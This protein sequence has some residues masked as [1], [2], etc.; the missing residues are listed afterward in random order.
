M[1]T[2][3]V[4]SIAVFL[5]CANH[6]DAQ[7]LP[8]MKEPSRTAD[9]H[10]VDATACLRGSNSS[11]PYGLMKAA[12]LH[13]HGKVPID[14]SSR[15]LSHL[16]ENLIRGFAGT[17]SPGYKGDGII[18]LNAA[19]HHPQGVA[20]D[21]LGNVYIADSA[22][23]RIRKVMVD[24]GIIITVAGSGITGYNGDGIIA[25][26]AKLFFPTSVAIDGSYNI[27]IADNMNHRIRKVTVLDN[28]ITT[29]AGTGS[30]G[31]NGDGIKATSAKLNAPNGIAL[32]TSNNIYIADTYNNRIRKLTVSTGII[33][34]VAG[35]GD[36]PGFFKGEGIAA[37]SIYLRMPFNVHIDGFGDIY[38]ADTYNHRV[39]KVTVSTGK[40]TT[41][42]GT[43]S[44]GYNGDGIKATSARLTDPTGISS[45][46]LGDIYI[47][48]TLDN[49]IRKVSM[50]T[51]IITTVAGTGPFGTGTGDYN[52]DF[53]EATSARLNC[54]YDVAVDWFGHVFIADTNNNRIRFITRDVFNGPP[55]IA[56]PAVT[57]PP[58]TSPPVASPAVTSPP[59]VSRS[60]SRKRTRRPSSAPRKKTPNDSCAPRN[61]LR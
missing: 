50:S 11:S 35:A 44:P 3:F 46:Y 25:T 61:S 38:I 2:S 15:T 13:S 9:D 31:Y 7:K 32:D 49:R 27:Y 18:A 53:I 47:A 8:L 56:S 28:I 45:D 21:F 37:T 24:T 16:R 20:V 54:P 26:S 33:T 10:V 51:G 60:P 19:V 36:G 41:V 1:L 29:V 6:V 48:D 14:L 30:Y 39:L 57:S 22:N 43:G 59:V 52:G 12:L 4:T 23:N 5:I 34:T 17:G 55:P 42:A 58:V 40:I